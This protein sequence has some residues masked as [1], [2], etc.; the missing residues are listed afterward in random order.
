MAMLNNQRVFQCTSHVAILQG[1]QLP[2]THRSYKIKPAVWYVWMQKHLTF[3]R[4]HPMTPR[5]GIMIHQPLGGAQG[6]RAEIV[7][8]ED[9]ASTTLLWA[10]KN[11]KVTFSKCLWI[12]EGF[13]EDL[14]IWH[15]WVWAQKLHKLKRF[16]QSKWHFF[17]ANIGLWISHF[18]SK[19]LTPRFYSPR[20]KLV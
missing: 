5:R 3:P 11:P 7:S 19:N 2:Q 6:W 16:H 1:V 9:G 17:S 18:D 10:N 14:T 15:V 8:V 13:I 12:S 4:Y 20:S